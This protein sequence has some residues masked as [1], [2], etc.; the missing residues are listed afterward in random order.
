MPKVV[1]IAVEDHLRIN[2]FALNLLPRP[3]NEAGDASGKEQDGHEQRGEGH[4]VF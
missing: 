4:I 1:L 2:L 3:F